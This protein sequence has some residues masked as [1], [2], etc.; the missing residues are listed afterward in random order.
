MITG[1][2]FG[3]NGTV[4]GHQTMV[5]H[6]HNSVYPKLRMGPD[7]IQT[8]NKTNID[9]IGMGEIGVV[10]EPSKTLAFEGG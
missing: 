9:P 1:G 6:R 5:R 7:V 2:N 8:P 3:R 4:F 10:G